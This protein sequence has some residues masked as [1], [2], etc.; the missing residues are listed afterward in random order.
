MADFQ[1]FLCGDQARNIPGLLTET[2]AVYNK[3]EVC[4]DTCR[5]YA[6]HL[7]Y[8]FVKTSEGTFPD[9]HG[10]PDNVQDRYEIFLP[11]YA[12]YYNNSPHKSDFMGQEIQ[13][14]MRSMPLKFNADG[15]EDTSDKDRDI[16]HTITME[17]IIGSKGVSRT[18]DLSGKIPDDTAPI[19]MLQVASHDESC[20]KA[21]VYCGR[22]WAHKDD[23]QV[24][25]DK[26][27]GPSLHI[28]PYS[29]ER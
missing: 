13:N 25:R 22:A 6:N 7:G 8:F 16:K 9:K 5:R 2:L 4:V 23:N 29:V 3:D 10:S 11:Q 28:A 21:G 27:A 20:C 12:H 26:S 19:Y 18:F 1:L 15:V 17:T 14:D 24:C